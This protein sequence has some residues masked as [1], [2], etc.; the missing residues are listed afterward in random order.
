MFKHK[1]NCGSL[2]KNEQK[3]TDKHPDYTGTIDIHG[4]VMRIAGWN[5][6]GK[7]GSTFLSLQISE[8][9]S[10][11]EAQKKWEEIPF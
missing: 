9:K 8:E 4:K 7:E 5:K 6:A 1:E 2:F 3:K 10:Q 11:K